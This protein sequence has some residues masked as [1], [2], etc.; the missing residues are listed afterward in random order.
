MNSALWHSR[1]T[2]PL[3]IYT[4]FCV[5][6]LQNRVFAANLYET[7]PLHHW[8]GSP[9]SHVHCE[10]KI[11]C[12]YPALDW[13]AKFVFSRWFPKVSCKTGA[14]KAHTIRSFCKV[15]DESCKSGAWRAHQIRILALRNSSTAGR[16][17]TVNSLEAVEQFYNGFVIEVCM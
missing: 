14:L 10:S 9:N 7:V 3:R 11:N 16:T 5:L 13:H 12:D 15:F 4:D 2:F 17:V 1:K 8:A 6:A